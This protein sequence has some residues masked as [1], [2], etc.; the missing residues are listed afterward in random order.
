ME[1]IYIIIII[2]IIMIIKKIITIVNIVDLVSFFTN[3]VQGSTKVRVLKCKISLFFFSF[4]F[5][6]L[7]ATIL[8]FS[9]L[10]PLEFR[11]L[12]CHNWFFPEHFSFGHFKDID[13]GNRNRAK[14]ISVTSLPKFNS[15]LTPL[16]DHFS[17]LSHP[18]LLEF[19]Q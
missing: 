18:F 13:L 15:F 10:T 11:Q 16:L 17:L 2:I 1:Y 5:N 14:G 4:I 8:F 12:D 19:R 7:V 6:N 3:V 9:L